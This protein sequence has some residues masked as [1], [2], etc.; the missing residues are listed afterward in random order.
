MLSDTPRIHS[1]LDLLYLVTRE[2]NT[3]LDI[4]LILNRVLTATVASVGASDASLSLF[5]PKGNLQ[6]FIPIT[7][8]Q[9]QQINPATVEAIHERG[10]VSW[11]KKNKEAILINDTTNDERWYQNKQDDSLIN[12]SSV[13]AVP[14]QAPD[15]PEQLLGVLTINA[16]EAN[17]F[18]ESDLS[19]LTII[20][21]Q[22]AFAIANARLFE[23]E[24]HRRRVADILASIA[25][26]INSTLDLNEVLDLILK[27]LALVVD[28]DS[29]SILL[30]DET[31]KT[32]AV[33]AARGFEDMEDALSVSLPEIPNT[34]HYN[35]V[36]YKTPI[37]ISDV[38]LESGWV[39]SSS[40]QNVHS[41]IGAPLV[42]RDKVIG[43]LTVDSHQ[44]NKY[45]PENAK[46]VAA[47]AD[48]AATA[49]ANAQTVAMFQNAEASYTALFEHSTDVIIITDY[50]GEI[51]N[52]NRKAC[53]ILLSPKT[54]LIGSYISKINPQLQAYLTEHTEELKA[55]A[56][57]S[58][59]ID[60]FDVNEVPIPL[61][62]Q[63]RQVHYSGTDCVQW[64]G[65]DISARKEAEKMRQDLV[66]MLVHDLRGPVG[67]LINV[68][69]MLPMLI[70]SANESPAFQNILEM[71][72]R[73][74][75]EVRDLI[76]SM[77]DVGLLEQGEIPLQRNPVILGDMVEAV[78]EQ[79][80]P[81]ASAKET[82][83][84]FQPLPDA[85]VLFIDGGMIRR[86]LINLVDNAIKYTPNQGT[87]TLTTELIDEV[88]H[89]TVSDNGPGI[90]PADQIHIFDKFSRVD[91]TSK[92]SGVGLGLAFCKLATEAHG[93]TISVESDGIPGQG[94]TFRLTVP[95]GTD[96]LDF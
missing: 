43:L 59:E 87:V 19:M 74:G 90:S 37:V 52:V 22:A 3:G 24:Q 60:I 28:Y 50:E 8:F 35:A 13:I 17:Y 29:S 47:F 10:L 61:E 11:V 53:Q 32:L 1:R 34:P 49:V 2:F 5:D 96:E 66:N 9:M 76:D 95:I 94:S 16:A 25:R 27:H 26:T 71:A 7:G 41:W 21:D 77:L 67:N 42:A 91:H 63:G 65:R 4:D 78:H 30:Y 83:L 64:A 36:H 6:T 75:Q 56:E 55:L 80:E 85:P 62:I 88:L 72:R 82:E 51:L 23:A 38:D 31:G 40:S 39:K 20:A 73:S 48:Q 12:S 45:S 69:E 57:V 15:H 92:I 44:I 86:V 81:R 68:I 93:G 54:D 33:W 14:I 89:F 79:V 84:I 58:L 18:D 70:D 46:E